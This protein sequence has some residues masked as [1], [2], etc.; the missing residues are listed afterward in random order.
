MAMNPTYMTFQTAQ[1]LTTPEQARPPYK[2]EF[3]EETQLVSPEEGKED[4]GGTQQ[5]YGASIHQETKK[6][7]NSNAE[8]PV[9]QTNVVRNGST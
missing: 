1:N 7:L 6:G 5:I 9:P 4:R 3:Q 8:S 2:Y